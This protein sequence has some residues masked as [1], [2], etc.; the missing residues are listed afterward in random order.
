MSN[1]DRNR[2]NGCR[3][4]TPTVNTVIRIQNEVIV[5]FAIVRQQ[6]IQ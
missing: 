6:D 5:G 2:P 1:C 3:R 4:S